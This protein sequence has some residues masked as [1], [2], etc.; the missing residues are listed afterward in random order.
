MPHDWRMTMQMNNPAHPGEVIREAC[1]RPMGLS[2]TAA[3]AGWA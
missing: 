3:A 1:L 2:V